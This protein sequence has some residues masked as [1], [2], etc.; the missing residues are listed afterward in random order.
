MPLLFANEGQVNAVVPYGLALNT[1]Q[2]IVVR[3]G[4]SYSV[5]ELI[6]VAA[7]Q[8]AVFTK[9]QTGKGQGLIFV[10]S[11]GGL[12]LA[13]A[14]SPARAEDAIVIYCSGLG[15]VSPPV[16]AGAAALSSPLS[17]TVNPVSV[18]IGGREAQVFFAGLA[19]G[20]AGLYQVNAIVP[21]GI[22]PG[23][24]APVSLTVAGQTSPPVAMAVR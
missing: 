15:A 3:R 19:P 24:E 23:N 7:A 18:T 21:P 1:R 8:P 13:D 17:T 16:A 5:P 2:Q 22:N 14:A 12:R 6:T 4:N 9:E 20:F 11:P 10:A